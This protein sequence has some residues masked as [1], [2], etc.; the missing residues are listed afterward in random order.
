MAEDWAKVAS[1]VLEAIEEVGF[2]VVLI[3]RTSGK[4]TPWDPAAEVT[5]ETTVKAIDRK[6]SRSRVDG[7]SEVQSQRGIIIPATVTP[8][9]G[10][11]IRMRGQTHDISKVRAVAPG[12]VDVMFILDIST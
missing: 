7:T 11:K 5:S 2:N 6:P 12:G 3:V 10:D 1:D 4:A 9:L 8:K